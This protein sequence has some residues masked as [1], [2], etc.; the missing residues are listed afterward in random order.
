MVCICLARKFIYAAPSLRWILL[1]KGQEGEQALS[2]LTFDIRLIT[3]GSSCLTRRWLDTALLWSKAS[4]DYRAVSENLK[5]SCTLSFTPITVKI[6]QLFTCQ[7]RPCFGC[8]ARI[9]PCALGGHMN[10]TSWPWKC[11]AI[12]KRDTETGGN[13]PQK[14]CSTRAAATVSKMVHQSDV[15]SQ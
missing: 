5:D 11:D 4:Q 3:A 15:S 1:H 8:F 14:L 6:Q 13:S 7:L 10:Y 12:N 9:F 2:L